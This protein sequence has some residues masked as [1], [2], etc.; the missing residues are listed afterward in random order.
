MSWVIF[1]QELKAKMFNSSFKSTNEFADFFTQK[2]DQCM[3]RGLDLT[4]QNTVIKGNTELMRVAILSALE[5]GKNSK[6]TVFYNQ[7][8]ALLGKGAVAYWTGAELGKIPPLIPAPG[9]ILNLAVVSNTAT[10]PGTWPTVP[11]P[12]LPSTSNDPYLDAFILQ[13]TIHLQ[14][15]SGFCNTIS[16]YPPP[17]TPG[18]AILP[19]VGFNVAAATTSKPSTTNSGEILQPKPELSPKDFIMSPEEIELAQQEY[20]NTQNEIDSLRFPGPL[21]PQVAPQE[22]ELAINTL[23]EYLAHTALRIQTKEN[24]SIDSDE[25]DVNKNQSLLD[26]IAKIIESAKMDLNVREIGGNNK[27]KRINEMLSAVGFRNIP[28]AWCAAAV[29][30]WFRAAG[31]KSPNSASC[32]VWLQWAKSNRTY[33]QKPIIGGAILY[34]KGND[35]NHIGIVESYDEKTGVITPIEG[36]TIPNGFS[37][38]GGGVYRKKVLVNSKRILGYVI[39]VPK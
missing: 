35:A 23:D 9:T 33:S 5:N 2:Y 37:R 27:G 26:Y 36:N 8:I 15:V 25:S 6:T 31:I 17:A 32:D 39:P 21:I 22:V 11:F 18:P 14:T 4:T 29:S 28:A 24:V 3:K 38:E 30:S 20:V 12:V 16:Q 7:S 1:K 34:G 10:N 19:W 13:A